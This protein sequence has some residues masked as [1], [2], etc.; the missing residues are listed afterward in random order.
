LY[1]KILRKA[2]IFLQIPQLDGPAGGI[3]G[4]GGGGGGGGS[5]GATANKTGAGAG[6]D[7]DEEFEELEEENFENLQENDGVEE[8]EACCD[9][10]IV[11]EGVICFFSCFNSAHV[12]EI[13]FWYKN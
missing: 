7:S 10:G 6:R 4:V 5:G 13:D 9:P 1:R 8:E 3:G 2:S 11:E 12:D